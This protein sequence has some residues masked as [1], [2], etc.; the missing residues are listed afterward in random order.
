MENKRKNIC[1]AMMTAGYLLVLGVS[2]N[3]K[4]IGILVF[5]ISSGL[6]LLFKCRK[7]RIS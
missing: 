5:T 3:Q 4:Q 7:E 1:V 6:I 2:V